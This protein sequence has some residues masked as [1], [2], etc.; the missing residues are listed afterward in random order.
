MRRSRTAMRSFSSSVPS[1]M[2]MMPSAFA[3]AAG[4]SAGIGHGREVDE[5][6]AAREPVVH[7]VRRVDREAALADAAR[8]R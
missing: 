8:D 5:G 3:I 2:S 4:T 1:P 6:D 7:A